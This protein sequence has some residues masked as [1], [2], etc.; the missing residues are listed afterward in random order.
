MRRII[1][2]TISLSFLMVMTLGLFTACEETLKEVVYSELTTDNAFTTKNDAQAAVNSI[3]QPLHRVSNRAIFYLNDMPT[4]ACYSAGMD[5]ELLNEG[6]MSI[7][8]DVANS[9][10]GYYHMI[11][12]ANIAIDNI[13]LIADA[14]F[15]ED[16]A[17]AA[18]AKNALTAEAHF[19]RGFAYYMLT[20]LFYTVPL[21]NSSSVAVD[22]LLPPASIE[23]LDE[24]IRTDLLTAKEYLPRSYA[25]KLDAG[26]ATYGAAAGFLCRLNMRT[27]GRTRQAGGDASSHWAEALKYADEV[28]SL[29]G[30]T[31]SLQDKVWNVFDPSTDATRYNDELIFAIRSSQDIPSGSSDIGMN[32]TPW[33]YDMGWNLFSIPLELTWMYDEEDERYSELMVVS[34]RNVYDNDN[35]PKQRFYQIPASVEKVGTVYSDSP[36]ETIYELGASYTRKYKYMRP[37]TYN[38][39]TNNNMPMLRLADIILCKAEILNE[40]NGPTDEAVTL[41]N[42]IRTRAFGNDSHNITLAGFSSKEALR[43]AICDERLL[44]LNNEGVR[45]PDLIRMGLWK[46]RLDKY[47]AA[48]KLKS[49]WREKNSVDANADF[50]SDWKVYPADFTENDIRRY[51]PAPKR[52]QDLNPE[53]ANNRNF[54][55]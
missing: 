48:I 53:L 42:R 49:E 20:D 19:M 23:E 51:Y 54:T 6:K 7:N 3:Y 46:D 35:S 45:R 26:R 41:V 29:E 4:D 55:K 32:F 5:N 43:D 25:N 36:T 27:A 10:D 28:L 40:M 8:G 24:Q 22:A 50:S 13:P 39:N 14:E 1:T 38:Y 16:E 9:W 21:V 30:S 37:G 44:E 17:T 34:F 12:R 2:S 31:Y 15:G 33:D 47:V 52:E 18:A 11:S